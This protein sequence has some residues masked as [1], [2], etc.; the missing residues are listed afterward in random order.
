MAQEV[1]NL[2]SIHKNGGL[3]PGLTQWVK[4][5]TL[6]KAVVYAADVAQILLLWCRPAEAA[7]IRLLVWELPYATAVALK[8][9]GDKKGD[10]IIINT[11]MTLTCFADKKTSSPGR[12]IL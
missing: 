9:W 12:N 4:D 2:T 1:K 3:I 5:P 11:I 7:P 8:R 6:L 10:L